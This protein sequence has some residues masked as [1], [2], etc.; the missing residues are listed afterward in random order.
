MYSALAAERA[1]REAAAD[2]LGERDEVG[3]HA[4]LPGRAAV[5]GGDAG[6]DLV[7]DQHRAV[8]VA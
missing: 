3:L 2:A 5:A 4:E 7:E 6:L 8:R 1:D